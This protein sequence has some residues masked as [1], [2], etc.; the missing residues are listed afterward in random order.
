[1]VYNGHQA[2]SRSGPFFLCRF[3]AL[4]L[5][6]GSTKNE[7]DRGCRCYLSIRVIKKSHR[8]E[9]RDESVSKSAADKVIKKSHRSER[10]TSRFSKAAADKGKLTDSEA[11]GTL[12]VK[13]QVFSFFSSFLP[14]SPPYLVVSA[15]PLEKRV[16]KWKK[17]KT[18]AQNQFEPVIYFIY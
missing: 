9:R 4:F 14:S 10:R 6:V 13:Y 8:S 7:T 15:V 16:E 2:M 11:A 12:E 17:K 1:M 3:R 18:L 5:R